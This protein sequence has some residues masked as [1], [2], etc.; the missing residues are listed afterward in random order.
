[1]RLALTSSALFA[2]VLAATGCLMATESK[3]DDPSEPAKPAIEPM[4]GGKAGQV[5]DDNGLKMQLVWC[6]PGI[7]TMEN[8]EIIEE[9]A[10]KAKAI[11]VRSSDDEFDAI[12]EPATTPV[13]E[14]AP[15]RT[16][17]I[18]PVRVFLSHGY[19]LG[20]YEVTQSEW[21]R[22]MATEPWK[23]NQFQSVGDDMPV[24]W[25]NWDDATSFCR[26]LTE[27]EREAGR[28]RAGWEY[29]LPTEAQWERACRARTETV[30]SFGD[31]PAKLGDYAW[32][33]VN[34][35][36][37][38]E[39]GVRGVGQKQPNPWGLY[40]MH[41]NVFEWCRDVYAAKLPGGRDPQ[42]TGES[43]LRI[44]RGG[45]WCMDGSYCRSAD[46]S[47]PAPRKDYAALGVGLRV[48]LCPG[49]SAK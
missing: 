25:V 5:R 23:G 24:T 7:F 10:A 17:R 26:K 29:M 11:S 36:A 45:S 34:A 4:L 44:F 27:Q 46:R 21:K 35:M 41:G 13:P 32:F 38:A 30:F 43:P 48:A 49:Q 28:L 47:Y 18:S 2:C 14:P 12:D 22:I 3:S 37:A 33:S 39:K 1:M 16:M 31:E 6:P 20:K 19:W 40:D 15:R 8:V 42:T 9:P